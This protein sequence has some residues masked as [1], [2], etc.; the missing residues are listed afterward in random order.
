MRNYSVDEIREQIGTP[1]FKK[2]LKKGRRKRK[3]VIKLCEFEAELEKQLRVKEYGA[4][5]RT[6]ETIAK[7]WETSESAVKQFYHRKREK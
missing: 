7:K 6:C 5:S 1:L 3:N 2:R 4:V